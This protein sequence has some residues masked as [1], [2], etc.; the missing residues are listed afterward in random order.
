MLR[1][2]GHSGAS[3]FVPNLGE[4]F[5]ES[6]EFPPLNSMVDFGLYLHLSVYLSICLCVN[7]IY[8]LIKKTSFYFL[9]YL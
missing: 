6:L 2:S 1:S 9:E 4:M 3:C 5:L 8:I 7:V